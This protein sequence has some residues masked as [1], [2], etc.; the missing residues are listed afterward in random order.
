MRDHVCFGP[1]DL[2]RLNGTINN[3]LDAALYTDHPV[4]D[5]R[6]LDLARVARRAIERDRFLE[7]R[8]SFLNLD[9]CEMGETEDGLGAR[10]SGFL[11]D[12]STGRRECAIQVAFREFQL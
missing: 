6:P 7:S 3:V 10:E 5:P 2:D 11:C 1:R 12:G 9:P 4:Q 8:A